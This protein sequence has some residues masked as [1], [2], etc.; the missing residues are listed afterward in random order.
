MSVSNGTRTALAVLLVA[1]VAVS[2][3]AGVGAGGRAP[4]QDTWSALDVHNETTNATNPA[5]EA[6]IS[7]DGE[8][9]LVYRG[10]ATGDATETEFGVDVATGLADAMLVSDANTSGA[11]GNLSALLTPDSVAAQGNASVAET[12]NLSE[13]D[14]SANLTRTDAE[15]SFDASLVATVE[16]GAADQPDL[17]TNGSVIVGPD[18]L[19]MDAAVNSEGPFLPAQSTE[20]A[21]TIEGSDTG[22][23]VSVE[24]VRPGANESRWGTEEAANDTLTA[25]FGGIAATFN[26]SADVTIAEHAFENDTNTLSINYTVAL[27]D[28]KNG[29]ARTVVNRTESDATFNLTAAERERLVDAVTNVSVE[30]IS[31]EQNRTNESSSAAASVHIADYQ[32]AV[33]TL[34]E[35]SA[36]RSDAL[37]AADV[38]RYRDTVDAREAATLVQETTWDANVSTTSGET[39][40]ALAVA[41]DSA[42]WS[43]Y[44]TEL[45]NRGIEQSTN[46]TASVSAELVDDSI[47][48]ETE[49]ELQ[50][51]DLVGEALDALR[52]EMDPEDEGETMALLRALEDSGFETARSDVS[53][54]NGTV[55]LQAGASFDN[56]TALRGA[57]D[58]LFGGATVGQIYGQGDAN[59]SATYVYL[60]GT[61]TEQDL[62]DRGLVGDGT[63]VFEGSDLSQF[64][65]MNTT[66]AA[67]YL[68]VQPPSDGGGDGGE[69]TPTPTPTDGTPTPTDGDDTIAPGQ[70]GFGVVVTV[71]AVVLAGLLAARRR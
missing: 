37:T 67:Q 47:D 14:L 13:L 10:N 17:E 3:V 38:D 27:T 66:A 68:G 52:A 9:V 44:V 22:Y 55:T 33:I 32:E 21:V 31:V 53:L 36:N 46:V 65:R 1:V 63:E 69:G 20:S 59:A 12:G 64:P 50:R 48:V 60:G 30:E 29:L 6:H 54:G 56:I 41:S 25:Q 39:S 5:D 40:V 8:V 18:E 7:D 61:Y 34:M 24:E 57:F 2:V 4:A 16:E 51:E 43:A 70:P 28:V 58:D 15:S 19:R 62:R 49:F 26:G 11:S 71:L 42:N 35:L 45:E 23:T